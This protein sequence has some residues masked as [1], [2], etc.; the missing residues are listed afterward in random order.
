MNDLPGLKIKKV[1]RNIPEEELIADLRE[2]SLLLN[3]EY[4]SLRNYDKHGR[5]NSSTFISRFGS[6]NKALDLAG[7]RVKRPSHCSKSEL[8]TNLLVLWRTLGRQPGQS[9]IKYGNS[10]Y[11]KR[12]Y[13][14]VFGSWNKTLGELEKFYSVSTRAKKIAG[15]IMFSARISEPLRT[16][17]RTPGLRLRMRVLKRDRFRCVLCGASPSARETVEL[18]ID[19]I[20]PWSKGG[21]TNA[22]NLQTLCSDCNRGKSDRVI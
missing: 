4:V 2:I 22:G 14:K 13:L 19:H 7:L 21:K 18:E 16:G 9:D 5:F 6:W 20:L 12:L 15:E 1:R 17:R 11:S 10:K 8:L 3:T